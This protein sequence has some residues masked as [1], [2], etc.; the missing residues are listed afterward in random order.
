MDCCYLLT[1]G[2][3]T[4]IG[5]TNNIQRRLDQHNGKKAGGAKYT[6]R[7]TNWHVELQVTGFRTRGEALQFEWA[8]KSSRKCGPRLHGV[9]GRKAR[10]TRLL[11]LERWT[12]NAPLAAEVPLTTVHTP[13]VGIAS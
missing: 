8:W 10:L 5:V 3:R 4:Y 7:S 11:A 2:T 9:A 12:S 13:E 6:K 1:D